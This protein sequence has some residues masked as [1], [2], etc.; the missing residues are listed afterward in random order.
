[1]KDDQ[2]ICRR[3]LAYGEIAHRWAAHDGLVEALRRLTG[4]AEIAADLFRV[5]SRDPRN[6]PAIDWSRVT[7]DLKAAIETATAALAAAEGK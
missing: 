7:P 4:Q 1:M 2:E 3:I 6:T 5:L